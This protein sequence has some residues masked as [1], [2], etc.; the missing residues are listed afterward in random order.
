M[1]NLLA[2]MNRYGVTNTDIEEVLECSPRT[3]TNKLSGVT[4]F[5][6]PEAVKLRD[7]LFPNQRLEYLFA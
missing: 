2:E 3:V 5:T 4:D 6:F 1:K 7:R